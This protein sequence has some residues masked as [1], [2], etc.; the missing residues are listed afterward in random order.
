MSR[1][2]SNFETGTFFVQ[3]DKNKVFRIVSKHYVDYI[4]KGSKSKVKLGQKP[5]HEWLYDIEYVGENKFG[6]YYE[7]RIK[8]ECHQLEN[9]AM[10]QAI[11][12]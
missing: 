9:Q 4:A 6:R 5:V 7:S 10:P 11:Y 12:D 8:E 3:K 1:N 2:H